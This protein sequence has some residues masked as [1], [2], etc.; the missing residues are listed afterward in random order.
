VYRLFKRYLIFVG[1]LL[2]LGIAFVFAYVVINKL[3][4][5]A[6][7]KSVTR[8][9][10]GSLD[11]VAVTPIGPVAAGQLNPGLVALMPGEWVKISEQ[12][13]D[14]RGD[15]QRQ[16][17]AGA[18]FDP[19]RRRLML[20]GSDTHRQNWDNNVRFF[21]MGSLSWSSS[22]PP[23]D[24]TTYRVNEAGL[25]VAGVGVERP[26]A[27]HTFD[28][29]EFDPGTDRLLVFS[30]PGHM[31]P[32]KR[33]GMDKVLWDQIREHPA[34]SYDVGEN[35]W[36]PLTD[37]KAKSFFTN[38][39]AFDAESGVVYGVRSQSFWKLDLHENPV[40]WK[41]LAK[42][43]AYGWHQSAVYDA[44]Q[45]VIVALGTNKRSDAVWQYRLADDH[46]AEMPTPGARP[47]GMASVPAV[48]HPKRNRVVVLVNDRNAPQPGRT[49]TWLYSVADDRWERLDGASIPFNIRMN[50]NMVYDP[51]HDLL[52]LVAN[53]SGEP[54]AVWA[55]R[56]P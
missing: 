9:V 32:K 39:T 10:A 6:I 47:P 1:V 45:R 56:L 11:G 42:R 5:T 7:G 23:D 28:A 54:V 43:G 14:A 29:V 55:L 50:Y 18:A 24:P 34:W 27:M 41:R 36:T 21:D 31:S 19:H 38:G 20:F 8:V 15:F 40:G 48:Y 13:G 33:W 4:G 52:V 53:L 16:S 37:G 30:H 3:P 46:V 17:H 12:E 49:D 26:W 35:R 25:P 44:A 2:N 22:Y 51:G